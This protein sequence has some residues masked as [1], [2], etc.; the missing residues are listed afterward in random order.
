MQE[1]D[2]Y[3]G[4]EVGT[5]VTRCGRPLYH[6]RL[7]SSWRRQARRNKIGRKERVAKKMYRKRGEEEKGEGENISIKMKG[8]TSEYRRQG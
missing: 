5:M 1:A 4:R 8:R 3:K 7:H 6:A 2:Q